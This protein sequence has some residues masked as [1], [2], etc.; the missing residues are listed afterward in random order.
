MQETRIS[1][2]INRIL[3]VPKFRNLLHSRKARLENRN[4]SRRLK[5]K[6]VLKKQKKRSFWSLVPQKI[7]SSRLKIPFQVLNV[8]PPNPLQT[9]WWPHRSFSHL[10]TP[11]PIILTSTH[12]QWT[13]LR[14]KFSSKWIKEIHAWI[15]SMTDSPFS[16][17]LQV[18][19]R[20]WINLIHQ[21]CCKTKTHEILFSK[22]F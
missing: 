12:L 18:S 5:R 21:Y 7:Q 16:N 6:S 15:F 17:R 20:I 19:T 14:I 9:K 13:F 2:R 22:I 1:F 10:V 8:M 3:L 4:T 11:S